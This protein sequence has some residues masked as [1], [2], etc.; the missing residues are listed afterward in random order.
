MANEAAV[1]GIL[2]KDLCDSKSCSEINLQ[3][4]VILV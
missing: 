3:D 1:I 4:V 2:E